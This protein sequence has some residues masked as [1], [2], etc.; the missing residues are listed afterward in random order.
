MIDR[1]RLQHLVREIPRGVSLVAI[2]LLLVACWGIVHGAG[3]TRTAWPH[4][5]YVPIVLASL[6]FGVAGGVVTALA[7]AILCGPFMPLDT[8]TGQAQDAVNWLT[9]GGF[10]LAIGTLTGTSVWSVRRGYRT[11]VTEHI[12][13]DIERADEDRETRPAPSGDWFDDVA[14]AVGGGVLYMVG[15]PIYSLEDGRL[16]TVEA[17]ARFD[18]TPSIPPNHWFDAA[19]RF[20]L[21]VELEFAAVRAALEFGAD[22]PDDVTLSVN[23][24]PALV[25]H[26]PLLDLLDAHRGLRLMVEVTEHAIVDDYPTLAASLDRV[27]AR[28]VLV[29]VDDAGGGFASLSHIVRLRPDVIKIDRSLTQ[30]VETDPFRRALADALCQ[31]GHGT[32]TQVVVEGIES[33][34]DLRQ[35]Q[36][37]GAD[38]AQGYL[39]GR[40]GSLPFALRSD[41]VRPR[42]R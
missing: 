16:V 3:G 38:A 30:H 35:W 32:D 25:A 4:V 8:G 5:F 12:L 18:T 9:R 17:L 20:G 27:R 13:E 23:A 37:I 22:L 33:R 39:L 14:R 7:A 6:P 40:P 10:F 1:G 36:R 34:D 29:A 24:S 28:G 26:P 19:A 42:G 21:G 2:A 15:Q 11:M 31:F 41:A